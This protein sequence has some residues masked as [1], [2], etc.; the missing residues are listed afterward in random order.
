MKF[1]VYKINLSSN[2]DF[3]TCC[4]LSTIIKTKINIKFSTDTNQIYSLLPEERQ[5]HLFRQGKDL[6]F[7]DM[8]M[9]FFFS[10]F[11]PLIK[12]SFQNNR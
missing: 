5:L 7:M 2:T 4:L 12:M 10:F 1:N 8:D 11:L 6:G 9:L 3:L